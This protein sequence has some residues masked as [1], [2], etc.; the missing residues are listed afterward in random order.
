MTLSQAI[1]RLVELREKHGDVLVWFD[2]PKC[3][4]SF[5]PTV[6]VGVAVHLT[7]KTKP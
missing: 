5:A 2:C 1:Q 7:E 4:E 6:V 3:G